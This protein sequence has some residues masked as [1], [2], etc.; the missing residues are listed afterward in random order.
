MANQSQ[1]YR[2]LSVYVYAGL[3]KVLTLQATVLL[4][5]TNSVVFL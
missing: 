5:K 2:G 3:R 1:T 4:A